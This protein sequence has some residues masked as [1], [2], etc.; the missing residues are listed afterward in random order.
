[1]LIDS[2]CEFVSLV[3]GQ[4]NEAAAE[5]VTAARGSPTQLASS[6]N[7]Y[8]KS[9]SIFI[10]V[11]QADLVDK[12]GYSTCNIYRCGCWPHYKQFSLRYLRAPILGCVALPTL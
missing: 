5:I 12:T 2:D 10:Q 3:L 6:S 7:Q 1:M 4:L 11:S 9:Y 8:S